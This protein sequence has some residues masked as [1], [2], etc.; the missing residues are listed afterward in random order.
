MS[1]IL[2][3]NATLLD[4]TGSDP[5]FPAWVVAEDGVIREVGTGSAPH[6]AGAETTD[7]GG[8]TLMPGL[9]DG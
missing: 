6:I 9:I 7:R 4:C 1:L 5:V 8:K 2:F 3:T